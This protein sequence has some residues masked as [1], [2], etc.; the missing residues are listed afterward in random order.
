MIHKS[1]LAAAAALTL[2]AAASFAQKMEGAVKTGEIPAVTDQ[3]TGGGAMAPDPP[4]KEPA[5]ARR[6][7][8][9]TSPMPLVIRKVS[10]LVESTPTNSDIEVN[11]VYV[12]ATPLQLSL[13]EGVH[14]L[15]VRKE[16]F[17][18]WERAVKAY[19]GLYVSATLV[20]EST[21]K[22]DQT[23]SATAQ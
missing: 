15:K 20:K 11:G 4:G 16:G 8:V 1:V 9:T 6:G 21:T 17:L 14:H 10:V 12:G 13:K 2:F 22:S 5:M 19:N 23:R 7:E 18:A 3:T